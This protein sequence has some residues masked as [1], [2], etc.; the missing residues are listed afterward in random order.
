M[1]IETV[2]DLLDI[3]WKAQSMKVRIDK[4]E[5]IKI[6]ESALQMTISRE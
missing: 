4:L 3:P 6:N 1:T 2:D 5:F